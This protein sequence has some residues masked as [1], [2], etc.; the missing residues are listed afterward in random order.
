MA[1]D[2]SYELAK[3]RCKRRKTYSNPRVHLLFI[4]IILIATRLPP[5]S[6]N[7]HR[8]YSIPNSGRKAVL[9]ITASPQFHPEA[10]S[11][12]AGE[13]DLYDEDKRL[14]RTGPNPL[15]N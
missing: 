2:L 10:R 15:H 7:H 3:I 12:P 13:S 4:W 5:S 11:R 1:Q 14:V 9:F 6:A 8:H